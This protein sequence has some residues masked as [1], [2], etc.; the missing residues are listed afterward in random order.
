MTRVSGVIFSIPIALGVNLT[1]FYTNLS[2]IFAALQ[3]SPWLHGPWKGAEGKLMKLSQTSIKLTIKNA[4]SRSGI[5][6]LLRS[7]WRLRRLLR[8]RWGDPQATASTLP[9]H[10]IRQLTRTLVI[11]RIAALSTQALAYLIQAVLNAAVGLQALHLTHPQH[12][13]QA[14]ATTVRRAWTIHGH[15][16]TSLPAALRAASP[17]DYR[18]NTDHLINNAYTAHT[19]AHLHRLMHNHE[20]EVQEVFTLTLREVQYHR[21]TCPQY[22]LHQRGVP[23]KVGARVWKHLQILLPHHQQV[24]QTNHRCRETGPLAVLHTNVGGGPTGSTSTLDLVGT[25]VHLV[26]VTPNQ[27]LALQRVGT[28]HVPFLQHPEWPNES[29]PKSHMRSAATQTRHLQPT[30]GDIREAYNLFWNTHKR[31]LPPGP[32]RG[33]QAHHRLPEQVEYVPAAT[34][35]AVLLP[36]PNELKATLRPGRARGNLWMLPPPTARPFCP[37]PLSHD[38]LMGDPTPCWRCV[39]QVLASP[40]PLLQVLARYRPMPAA[41]ATEEQHRW[42]HT[43]LERAAERS[44]ATVAW[45]PSAKAEWRFCRGTWDTKHPAIT[46]PVLAKH[47]SA[48]PEAPAYPVKHRCSQVQDWQTVEWTTFQPQKAYLPQYVYGYLTQGHEGKNDY[49]RT[50]A[51]AN[52]IIRQGVGVYATRTLRPDAN[53]PETST[54]RGAHIH[55]YQPTTPCRLPHT[56]HHNTVIFVDASGTTSLTPAAGAG[57]LWS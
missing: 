29:L 18:D 48:T 1:T 11:A 54:E 21:N 23:T 44:T 17:P 39:P 26:L 32:P 55:A 5:T 10:L 36:A 40:W 6:P 33:N 49:V 41:H 3:D 13:L 56:E 42:I 2:G 14:A 30:D 9:P 38:K 43:H 4:I 57:Q 16:P 34:V 19:A 46:F 28:Q 27:M 15:R 47:R 51:A 25:T 20:R 37:P 45:D 8:S 50:N 52:E 12:M 7:I 22:I 53:T 35:P 31:P 24:I